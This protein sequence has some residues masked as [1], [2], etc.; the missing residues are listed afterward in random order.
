MAGIF[1]ISGN[2]IASNDETEKSVVV[3]ALDV[4]RMAMNPSLGNGEGIIEVA[5][6]CTK[7]DIKSA[8]ALLRLAGHLKTET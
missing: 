3:D 8:A 6:S 5:A 7:A 4:G 1:D 2:E